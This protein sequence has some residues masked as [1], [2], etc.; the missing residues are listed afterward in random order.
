[1]KLLP[2][3]LLRPRLIMALAAGAGLA[4]LLPADWRWTTRG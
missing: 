3:L 4:V 1:M 2:S